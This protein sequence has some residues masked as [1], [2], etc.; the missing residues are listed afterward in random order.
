V[1]SEL[2]EPIGGYAPNGGYW[3]IDGIDPS[4]SV[5]LYNVTGETF[6]TN[7][8][9]AEFTVVGRGRHIDK[10]EKIGASGTL[11]C[12][13]RDDAVTT[14]RTKREMIESMVENIGPLYL[15][16][17][18]GDVR[19]VSLSDPD[20]TRIVSGPAEFVDL[21]IPYLEVF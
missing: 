5:R 21:S 20:I 4:F 6:K 7:H 18:F 11:S 16:N 3:L 10:G 9:Q 1:E 19:Q 17:P 2:T 13:L 15:R 12:S 14:A 8:E